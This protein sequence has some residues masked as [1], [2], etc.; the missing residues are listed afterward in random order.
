MLP[1]SA[2]APA[3]SDA[4]AIPNPAAEIDLDAVVGQ[5]L[6][7][8]EPRALAGD[9]AFSPF[10]LQLRSSLART[11]FGSESL[12]GGHHFASLPSP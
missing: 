2:E 6:E 3:V 5:P 7:E 12:P 11:G 9:P 10:L 8:E 1:P 4:W